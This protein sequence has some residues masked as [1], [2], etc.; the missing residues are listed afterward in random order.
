M[1][2]SNI[3]ANVHVL[4]PKS[5]CGGRKI[6][7][8]G[9]IEAFTHDNTHTHTQERKKSITIHSECM[10]F[11]RKIFGKNLSLIYFGIIQS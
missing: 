10:E 4:N 7:V 5:H 8:S 2:F 9:I 11:K 3:L 6:E 1:H